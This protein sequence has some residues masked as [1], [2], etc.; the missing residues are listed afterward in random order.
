MA[1]LCVLLKTYY[2]TKWTSGVLFY[3]L[4]RCNSVIEIHIDNENI[5]IEQC[6]NFKRFPDFM[7]EKK[8][9]GSADAN[10]IWLMLSKQIS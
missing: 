4:F 2:K 6:F 7:K 3:A 8:Y 10:R 5:K 1:I 9:A